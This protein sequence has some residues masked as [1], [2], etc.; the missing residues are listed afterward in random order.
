[1]TV[2]LSKI[3]IKNERENIVNESSNSESN[4]YVFVQGFAKLKANLIIWSIYRV[5]QRYGQS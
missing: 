2:S 4:K 5:Y 3:G 1:M